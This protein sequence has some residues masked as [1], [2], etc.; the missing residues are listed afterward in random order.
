M[1]KAFFIGII[2]LYNFLITLIATDISITT[3]GGDLG[4]IPQ[5]VSIFGSIVDA[6]QLFGGLLVFSVEGIPAFMII[7]FVYLV[8]LV[9]FLVLLAFIFDR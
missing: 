6:I 4:T 7:I 9:L 5:D 8:N 3:S 2:S 1:K